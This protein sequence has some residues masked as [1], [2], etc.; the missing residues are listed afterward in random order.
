[1]KRASLIAVVVGLLAVPLPG[2]RAQTL[3]DDMLRASQLGTAQRAT[4]RQYVRDRL[5]L[6]NS[7]DAQNVSAARRELMEPFRRESV[8]A[9]V[10]FR[11]AMSDALGGEM[12]QLIQGDDDLVA[13]NTLFIAG[14]LATGDGLAALNLGL[15]D[16]RPSVRYAAAS[17]FA[18]LI[19]TLASGDDAL[20]DKQGG[21][22]IANLEEALTAEP[23]PIVV[24]G[25]VIA[26]MRS[27]ESPDPAMQFDALTRMCRS[28]AAQTKRRRPQ[29]DDDAVLFERA[30]TRALSAVRRPFLRLAENLDDQFT[31]QAAIMSGQALTFALARM[32]AGQQSLAQDERDRL[33]AFSKAAETVLII[34]DAE[35]NQRNDDAI[36]PSDGGVPR[37]LLQRAASHWTGPNGILTRAPYNV[38]TDQFK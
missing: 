1:M 5:A 8:R 24:D 23:D 2:A 16:P 9:G 31:K 27:M 30:F 4:L 28:I 18:T 17:G 21:E 10:V 13:A 25:L 15:S 22:A 37:T 38:S 32:D 20:T 19:A 7:G 33:D 12:A 6:L 14:A 35:L 26:F 29:I 34:A 3:P 11:L 36:L